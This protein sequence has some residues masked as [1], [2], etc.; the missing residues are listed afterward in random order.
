MAFKL[1]MKKQKLPI[2]TFRNKLKLALPFRH[3]FR[4]VDI[5][6]LI[7]LC[8]TNTSLLA[9]KGNS[10]VR[11]SLML[12]KAYLNNDTPLLRKMLNKW[13]KKSIS[14]KKI[15]CNKA[16]ETAVKIYHRFIDNFMN[17]MLTGI[18]YNRGNQYCRFIK[19]PYL[20]IQPKFK[21]IY[22]RKISDSLRY[23]VI[24]IAKL[25]VTPYPEL[26]RNFDPHYI[27]SEID[28]IA[29]TIKNLPVQINNEF[30]N[31]FKNKYYI[32]PI[33]ASEDYRK[34]LVNFWGYMDIRRG[35]TAIRYNDPAPEEKKRRLDFL[36]KALCT[37]KP[38]AKLIY[39]DEELK[40]NKI[41]IIDNMQYAVVT[42]SIMGGCNYVALYNLDKLGDKA[43]TPVSYCMSIE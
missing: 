23:D 6:F 31:Q 10:R 26:Y 14:N 28:K 33:S 38:E 41:Y 20:F 39:F 2:Q 8:L 11:D 18:L 21:Y 34:C 32:L 40:I 27:L 22:V 7:L 15:T 17:G 29:D 13:S 9:Q 35:V 16:N 1:K 36:N 42:Y 19:S 43:Y 25:A 12:E 5:A 3:V 4:R 30:Y 37:D 24:K